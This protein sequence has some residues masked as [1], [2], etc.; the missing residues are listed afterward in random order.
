MDF[1]TVQRDNLGLY[2]KIFEESPYITQMDN[3]EGFSSSSHGYSGRVLLNM[4]SDNHHHHPMVEYPGSLLY[5]PNF[6]DPFDPFQPSFG[7]LMNQDLSTPFAQDRN[8]HHHVNDSRTFLDVNGQ[9]SSSR[10]SFQTMDHYQ[11]DSQ[12]IIGLPNPMYF[13]HEKDSCF[14]SGNGVVGVDVDDSNNQKADIDAKNETRVV[15]PQAKRKRNIDKKSEIVKGQWSPEE[16]GYFRFMMIQFL[17]LF[18][19]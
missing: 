1:D 2:S 10:A 13:D 15:V 7:K 5:S 16:D 19:N 12:A 3:Y 14:V 11:L 17:F 8:H 6:Y 9:D 18:F 4:N